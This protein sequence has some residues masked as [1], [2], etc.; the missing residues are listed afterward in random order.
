MS[1]LIEKLVEFRNLQA[2]RQGMEGYKVLQYPTIEE[3]AKVL[4][5]S[6]DELGKIKG[7]GPM[8]LKKYGAA[9]VA[10][11]ESCKLKVESST[12][13]VIPSASWRTESRNLDTGSEPGMTD[14][15]NKQTITVSEYLEYLN[16]VLQKTA[17][18]KIQ[19]EVTSSKEYPNGIYFSLKD[20]ND[21]GVLSCFIPL[22]TYRGFGMPLEQGMEIRIEGMPR[23]VKR[24]GRFQF[25]VENIELAG[26]GALKK[27][28]DLLKKKL[29]L[30]GIFA[31]KREMP[32]FIQS[33][34]I[35]TSRSGAVIHDFRNNLA[36][37][38][39]KLYLK[40]VRVEG[41]QAVGQIIN[42][43][44][45]FNDKSQPINR[46]AT[47]A[48]DIIVVM[49]GGGS[50]EDLQAF[51]NEQVV[52]AIF[53]SNIPTIVA[54]GH[55]KD[56]PLAQLTADV[57][58]STPTAAAHAVSDSWSRLLD[59]LPKLTQ[60]LIYG[61]EENVRDFELHRKNLE[62][63]LFLKWNTLLERFR[64]KTRV[65]QEAVGRYMAW[66]EHQ[67]TSLNQIFEQLTTRIYHQIQYAVKIVVSAEKVLQQA[68]PE[69]N[70]ELG[71]SIVRNKDGRIVK[72]VHTLK[73]GDTIAA[74]L[75]DGTVKSDVSTIL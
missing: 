56:V 25:T 18:V 37:L 22:Y 72:S 68:N 49:R 32:E 38:G 61:Y 13:D 43:L 10:L 71:Y 9:I 34:G 2:K 44:Q 8:K 15:D 27:T 3:I 20:K 5:T 54:I 57:M 70:L 64:A 26:E 53:A 16:L 19:G 51:N 6:L 67:N 63:K 11:V 65:I 62:N 12:N 47:P 23:M 73:I 50:L 58:V 59:D 36:P 35:I 45:L 17:D 74:Q 29:E 42:A 48:V 60:D 7:I 33:V 24:N 52:R 66:A 40:D 46:H 21:E 75:S 1:Q 41:G 30:E 55:D 4:P 14:T 28:Y 69:R 39:I 31:R